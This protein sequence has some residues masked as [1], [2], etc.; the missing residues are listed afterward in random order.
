MFLIASLLKTLLFETYETL[1][2]QTRVEICRMQLKSHL[3]NP[4][5]R[6]ML[7]HLFFCNERIQTRK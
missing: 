6:T 4:I 7:T 1:F 5:K 3:T 2:G